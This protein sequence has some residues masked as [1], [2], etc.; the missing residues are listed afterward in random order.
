MTSDEIASP[1]ST[2]WNAGN[3]LERRGLSTCSKLQPPTAQEAK[4]YSFSVALLS[5]TVNFQQVSVS[6][7]TFEASQQD[8]DK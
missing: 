7:T 5:G 6:I 8:D 2:R 3:E 1:E 4:S